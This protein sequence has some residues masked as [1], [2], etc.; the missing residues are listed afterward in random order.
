MDVD[1]PH[2]EWLFIVCSAFV[3]LVAIDYIS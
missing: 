2:S 3:A 1:F